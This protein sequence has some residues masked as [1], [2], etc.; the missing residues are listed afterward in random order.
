MI[1]A[2]HCKPGSTRGNYTPA[3]AWPEGCYVQWGDSGIV[4][5]KSSAP[6]GIETLAGALAGDKECIAPAAE[7]L[8]NSYTTAFFEA[9]PQ[10]PKTF[11]RGEGAT[12]AEAEAN[13]FTNL[14]RYLACPGHE[15]ER[16]GY[17]N[18]AGFC[19]HC[20]LFKSKAFEPTTLCCQC[21]TPTNHGQDKNGNWWC[22][23]CYPKMPRETWPAW[24]AR[25]NP[26]KD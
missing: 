8:A 1:I 13:A 17:T 22:K 10:A 26:V 24:R 25:R 19:R 5:R 16:R 14:Q 12:V 11:I 2:D 15:F 4:F 9:F 7:I 20:G 6:S 23:T 3:C 21:E 18:G